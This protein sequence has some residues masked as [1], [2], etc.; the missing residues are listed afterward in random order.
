M[1][2]FVAIFVILLLLLSGCKPADDAPVRLG[3]EDGGGTGY[4]SVT[5]STL[6]IDD[7]FF[8]VRGALRADIW[9]Q[10]GS[11]QYDFADDALNDQ[12]TLSDGSRIS[13]QYNKTAQ[14]L[15]AATFTDAASGKTTNFFEKLVELGVLRDAGNST[16]TPST[17]TTPTDP[18]NGGEGEII[19]LPDDSPKFQI[20]S[21]D[22]SVFEQ[23]LSLYADRITILTVIGLP[24]SYASYNYQKDGYILDV[25]TLTDGRVL[26]LDYG[27]GR[28]TL[29]G[30]TIKHL[31]GAKS[32]FLGT[33]S[34]QSRPSDFARPE[35]T[36]SQFTSLK[37]GMTPEQVYR[38]VGDPHWLEGNAGGYRD[39]YRLIDGRIVYLNFTSAHNKLASASLYAT[40]GRTTAL[41][42]S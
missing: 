13:L 34:P 17:P 32:T 19:D 29:R 36:V 2:R 16:T 9:K 10:L 8:V 4:G 24:S 40:D 35:Q 5:G 41:N 38:A 6:T 20:K 12:Y 31:N 26:Y 30:A 11:P 1:K 28:K 27:Y 7:F 14:T 37:A 23:S 39:A 42:L 22:I 33:S 21:Y 25:Y 3:S 15:F 18:S